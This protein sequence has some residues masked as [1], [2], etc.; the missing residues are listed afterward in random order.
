[1]VIGHTFD[2][3]ITT[4]KNDGGL[5][6]HLLSD[7]AIWGCGISTTSSTITIQSGLMLI[8]GRQIE[9]SGET[10][11]PADNIISNGYGRLIIGIDLSNVTVS[12]YQPDLSLEYSTTQTFP[13]LTQQNINN[14]G[15]IYQQELARVRITEGNIMNLIS[16][17]GKS[18]PSSWIMSSIFD[19]IYDVGSIYIGTTSAN[20]SIFFGGTW[21]QI[22]DRFLLAAGSVYN[23]GS[24]GGSDKMQA[25][26]HVFRYGSTTDTQSAEHTHEVFAT[27]MAMKGGTGTSYQV[28]MHEAPTTYTGT[29]IERHS[30]DFS[31]NGN[32][33]SSGGGN[34]QNMP[35]YLA[36]YV[37]K[38]IA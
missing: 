10:T 14:S 9:V 31:I 18:V 19:V 25:H 33:E 34:S 22:K 24:Q 23:A 16:S 13:P 37:W 20:P 35:P 5:Y 17:I 26:S 15:T 4:S 11:I 3:Q 7:G 2:Q 1:M 36:V 27:P 38:R 12:T 29:E 28:M 6:E 30:H 21:E 32:T 8:A